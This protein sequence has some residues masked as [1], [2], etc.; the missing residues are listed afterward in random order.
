GQSF[1]GLLRFAC[2]AWGMLDE[3]VFQGGPMLVQ[4]AGLALPTEAAD[5]WEAT[6]GE[7]VEITLHGAWGDVG[8]RGDVGVGQAPA[9][10]P[11]H[12]HLALDTG[13]WVVVAIVADLR[14]DVGAE[15]ERT[16]GSLSTTGQGRSNHAVEIHLSYG[17][18][19]NLSRA[20]YNGARR[21][22]TTKKTWP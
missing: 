15:G 3:V 7:L 16:H 10:Q 13:V 5:P 17:N 22:L 21:A 19:A 9:F 12:F 4:R 14:Q 11:Q 8:A 18:S 2:T 20:E 6:L 1:D